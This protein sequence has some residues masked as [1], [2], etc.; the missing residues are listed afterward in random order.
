MMSL[1]HVAIATTTTAF[2]IST[3]PQVL[4]LSALGALLPDLD[5]TES[6]LGKI[7]YPIAH[8]IEQRYAHRT[9]THCLYAT[10]AIAAVA[11]GLWYFKVISLDMAKALPTGHLCSCVADCFTKQGVQLFYPRRV[12]A[13][14][15]RNPNARLATGSTSEYWVLAFFLFLLV[16]ATNMH[17]GGLKSSVS[18]AL[19]N[20]N[21]VQVVLNAKGKDH[22][23][24]AHVQ[25][26]KASD[27]FPVNDKY[28]VVEQIGQE[29]LL[30]GKDGLYLTGK[31]LI[32]ERITAEA[33]Q[34]AVV[35]ISQVEI[36]DEPIA[37]KLFPHAGE[38]VFVSGEMT[39]ELGEDLIV[40]KP[41]GKF[42]SIERT[43][44]SLKLQSAPLNTVY[45]L[46]YEQFGSGQLTI[47]S[48]ETQ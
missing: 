8:W 2:L 38:L 12:W 36:K 40:P 11:T 7:C 47:K 45:R 21:S 34:P 30:Q 19:G 4:A 48:L 46:L 22:L 3:S 44:S 37:A 15:G 5:T 32:V 20:N 43:A 29:F 26:V 1:T 33:S 35:K 27:R 25:G 14:C 6:Y 39:I 13:V 16:V 17:E 10:M 31:D 24:Y 18:Q 41:V 42:H 23:V 9:I 28:L